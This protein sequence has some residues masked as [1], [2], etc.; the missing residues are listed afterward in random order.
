MRPYKKCRICSHKFTFYPNLEISS[1]TRGSKFVSV[2]LS[3]NYF[4]IKSQNFKET[5]DNELNF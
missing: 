5:R 3:N 2:C 1:G 4:H